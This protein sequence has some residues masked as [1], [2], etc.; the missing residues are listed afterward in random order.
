MELKPLD[1]LLKDTLT[2][3]EI[4]EAKGFFAAYGLGGKLEE[5]DWDKL[6]QA[7]IESVNHFVN[8]L[9]KQ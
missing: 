8:L 5:G 3:E 1:E 2:K 4:D 9:K 7:F 6:G